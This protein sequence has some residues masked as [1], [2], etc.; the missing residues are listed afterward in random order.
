MRTVL[1]LLALLLAF[2]PAAAQTP[3]ELPPEQ[4]R[5][6]REAMVQLR[7]PVTPSHTLDM[8]PAEAAVALRDTVRMAALAGMSTRQIVD[9]VVARYGEPMRILPKR[10][11][12]GLVAWLLTPLALVGGAV[13]VVLRLRAMR[14]QGPAPAAPAEASAL[15][16]ADRAELAA[17]LRELDGEPEEVAG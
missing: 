6:A 9:D 15:S 10:S 4:E 13:F 5:T 16:D 17:A 12:K 8:C 1:F 7:S 2:A 14:G 11:G 3:I